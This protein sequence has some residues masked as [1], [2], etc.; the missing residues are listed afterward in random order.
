MFKTETCIL[1]C[2]DH[3]KEAL[4]HDYTVHYSDEGTALEDAEASEW[5]VLRDG[6]A[7]CHGTECQKQVP[8]CV[9][10]DEDCDAAKCPVGCPCLLHEEVK[11]GGPCAEPD[12]GLTFERAAELR[13]HQFKHE[14]AKASLVA[15]SLDH[16]Q[17][18]E[19]L[20]DYSIRTAASRAGS[21]DV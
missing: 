15:A 20:N 10:E 3:C 17:A 12:C 1:M 6:R 21:S 13:W 5:A 9:C 19:Y 7:Y 16:P 8:D 11:P 4:E 2:C 18:W 14:R